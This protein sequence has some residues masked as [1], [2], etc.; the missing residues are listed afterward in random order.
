MD[1]RYFCNDIGGGNSE[2]YVVVPSY[3]SVFCRFF[4]ALLCGEAAL[5]GSVAVILAVAVAVA[6]AVAG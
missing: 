6:V 5:C 2:K 1:F 3:S 4:D